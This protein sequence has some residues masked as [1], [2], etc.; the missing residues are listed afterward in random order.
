MTDLADLIRINRNIIANL[1]DVKTEQALTQTPPRF[2]FLLCG[3]RGSLLPNTSHPFIHSFGPD[4]LVDHCAGHLL[5]DDDGLL[6][7]GGLDN[8]EHLP[9][10]S[11]LDSK[12][13]KN[14]G[15][16]VIDLSLSGLTGCPG[17]EYKL[18]LIVQ[19]SLHVLLKSLDRAIFSKLN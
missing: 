6:L 16:G 18:L 5:G 14:L 17:E 1:F 12:I 15:G 13:G 11:L 8:R 2:S 3:F 4:L 9:V 7:L 10:Q 19:E